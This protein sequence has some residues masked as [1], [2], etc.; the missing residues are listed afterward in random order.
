MVMPSEQQ[1]QQQKM[2]WTDLTGKGKELRQL[3]SETVSVFG[4]QK[5]TWEGI[6]E[7]T[8]TS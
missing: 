7:H 2:D 5:C 1:Q 3:M 4:C 6:K 8:T